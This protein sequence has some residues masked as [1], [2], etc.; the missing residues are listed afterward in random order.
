MVKEEPIGAVAY[1]RV[2][3]N[4]LWQRLEFFYNDPSKNFLKLKLTN[5]LKEECVQIE[6][7]LQEFLDEDE[8]TVNY[9]VKFLDVVASHVN[10]KNTRRPI[11]S[12]E[13]L[14][15]PYELVSG[16]NI[17][18][19]TSEPEPVEYQCLSLWEFPGPITQVISPMP[20]NSPS[21]NEI[22]FEIEPETLVGGKEMF[23][24]RYSP[25]NSQ[26]KPYNY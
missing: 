20:Y 11:L 15:E 2:H 9:E 16:I 13:I 8:I 1:F 26:I 3:P 10:L 18:T 14:S 4:R 23:Y 22:R 24:F 6:Q 21:K 5:E 19:L 17:I 7:N 25:E 12:F